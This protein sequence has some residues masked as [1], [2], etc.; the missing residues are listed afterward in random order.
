MNKRQNFHKKLDTILDVFLGKINL[1]STVIDDATVS[2]ESMEIGSLVTIQ[3]E[4]EEAVSPA[5]DGE[6][7][8]DEENIIV[9]VDG[10]IAEVKPV[11][12]VV[13]A[14]VETVE[15]IE[16]I[17]TVE[18]TQLEEVV[19]EESQTAVTDY[20]NLENLKSLID[21]SKDGFY[22][23]A[24]AVEGGKVAWGGCESQVKLAAEDE[25]LKEIEAKFNAEIEKLGQSI[26]ANGLIQAPILE[27]TNKPFT[28]MDKIAMQLEE[29]RKSKI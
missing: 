15:T 25:R 26:K 22:T 2:W 10:K 4:G 13:E 16:T 1:A 6:Y 20:L 12:V 8:I 29:K 7:K 14:T 5:P 17:E 23:I 27:I 24:F 28:K 3:I 21:L 9:V 11:E 19:V 18:E